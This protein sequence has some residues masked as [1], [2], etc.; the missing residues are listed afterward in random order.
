MT[1]SQ[2]STI[3]AADYKTIRNI[4]DGILTGYGQ[5]FNS[6]DVTANTDIISA[7]SASHQW[8]T[9]YRDMVTVANHQGTSISSLTTVYTNNVQSGSLIR[10]SDIQVFLDAANL[11]YTNRY[12]IANGY[13][14]T[15]TLTSSTTTRK[16]GEPGNSP[17]VLLH[18]F[19]VKFTD[20]NA[21]CS[22]F[23]AGG[24]IQFTASRSGGTSPSNATNPTSNNLDWQNMLAAMGTITMG[25]SST[26]GTGGSPGVG[27][28]GIT[29]DSTLYTKGGNAEAGGAVYANN[30]YTIHAS[31]SG[32]T[33]S[34]NIYF[35][36]D[37]KTSRSNSWGDYDYVD[38]T[39]TS[40]VYLNVPSVS[41]G[42]TVPTPTTTGNTHSLSD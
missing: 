39:L 6:S 18:S 20:Y 8:Y 3:Q 40:T 19:N 2:N 9:L 26:S 37:G 33:I 29:S 21:A 41:G 7:T 13:Y 12:N 32:G 22:Y 1:I 15:V 23:N 38:G 42:V 27:F 28:Y 10:A 16:W 17:D 4:V 24:N 25:P 34:F 31:L 11:L 30:Y 36:N 5:S 35:N 14:N